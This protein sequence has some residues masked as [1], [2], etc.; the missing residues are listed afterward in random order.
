MQD[1][2]TANICAKG[3]EGRNVTP[4]PI[5]LAIQGDGTGRFHIGDLYLTGSDGDGTHLQL[6]VPVENA[7]SDH[8]AGWIEC[9]RRNMRQHGW[10]ID[11]S[12]SVPMAGAGY[13]HTFGT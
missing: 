13:T 5:D 9:F 1:F 11:G 7:A 2:L 12:V 10:R 3:R 8:A 4:A 6:K